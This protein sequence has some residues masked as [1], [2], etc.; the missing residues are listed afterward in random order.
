ME[1]IEIIWMIL[2]FHNARVTL[3][4]LAIHSRI[5][6]KLTLGANK[7]THS[8]PYMLFISSIVAVVGSQ[9]QLGVYH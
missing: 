7:R 4:K 9:R 5:K 2:H 1:Q 6:H 8:D 3:N